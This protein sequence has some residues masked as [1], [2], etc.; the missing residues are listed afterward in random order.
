MQYLQF[1]SL[2]GILSIAVFHM[3]TSWILSH[4]VILNNITSTTPDLP[5]PSQGLDGSVWG[6]MTKPGPLRSTCSP[7]TGPLLY[8]SHARLPPQIQAALFMWRKH[9]QA[10]PASGPPEILIYQTL[11]RHSNTTSP[12]KYTGAVPILHR[13]LL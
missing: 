6:L 1:I 2:T 7:E 12:P 13:I 8:C 4:S 10:R 3:H 11:P 5:S 9:F